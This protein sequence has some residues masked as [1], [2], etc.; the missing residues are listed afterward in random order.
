MDNLIFELTCSFCTFLQYVA[1]LL[2]V[3]RYLVPDIPGRVE[4]TCPHGKIFFLI[5]YGTNELS[6]N[7]F[8]RLAD[9]KFIYRALSR[10]VPRN[11]ILL[12]EAS[13]IRDEILADDI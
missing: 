3:L 7:D 4:I 2:A 13:T 8:S 9:N 6:R 10:R 1:I 5:L 12:L 11:K